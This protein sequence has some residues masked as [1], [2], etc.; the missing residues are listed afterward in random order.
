MNGKK[1]FGDIGVVVAVILVLQI[2]QAASMPK[3]PI[4]ETES[5]LN[6]GDLKEISGN[7]PYFLEGTILDSDIRVVV[8]QDGQPPI[9]VDPSLYDM[10]I[11]WNEQEQILEDAKNNFIAIYGFDPCPPVPQDA[12]PYGDPSH[13][14]L[15]EIGYSESA[16][17][18]PDDILNVITIESG[19]SPHVLGEKP[20]QIDGQMYL[21]VFMAKDS[22]HRLRNPNGI[23]SKTT[24]GW[25]RF[26]QFGITTQTTI[27]WNVWDASDVGT[28]HK[29]ILNDLYEDC[30]G[31]QQ[32]CNQMILG[33]VRNADHNGY[34]WYWNFYAFCAEDCWPNA[35]KDTLVQHELTHAIADIHDDLGW[36]PWDHGWRACIINY[37]YLYTGTT[38]WCSVCFPKVKHHIQYGN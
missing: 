34:A 11:S 16:E 13:H 19:Q 25:N 29:D 5:I 15:H 3:Q 27:F 38:G 33:W 1:I 32:Y 18:L 23:V 36:W 31:Y 2:P 10:V 12:W 20:K 26:N 4:T 28:Y 8:T 24:T 7:Y 17:I 30:R 37:F 35:P 14:F 6:V 22:A 9:D 21:F